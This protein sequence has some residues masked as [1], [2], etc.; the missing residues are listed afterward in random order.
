MERFMVKA[1]DNEGLIS[2]IMAS[3]SGGYSLL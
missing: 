2:K 1:I 3:H